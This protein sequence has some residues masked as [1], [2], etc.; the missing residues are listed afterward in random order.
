MTVAEKI[1]NHIT[2]IIR[3]ISPDSY[4]FWGGFYP[5]NNVEKI[6]KNNRN[7]DFVVRNEG[8]LVIDDFLTIW[9]EN[10]SI[11]FKDLKSISY[12]EGNK[13]KSTKNILI[14]YNLDSIK[15]FDYSLYDNKYIDFIILQQ[16]VVKIIVF[17]VQLIILFLKNLEDE[18]S[19][20]LL[21]KL[22]MLKKL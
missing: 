13:I 1:S 7:I 17:T 15:N 16:E 18:R 11:D 10:K 3:E 12:L 6:L 21:M 2:N 8:E 5:T 4:I 14:E 9:K 22:N 19:K 20:M